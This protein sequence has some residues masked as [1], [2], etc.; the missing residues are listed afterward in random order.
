MPYFRP[1]KRDKVISIGECGAEFVGV[2]YADE[3]GVDILLEC[4]P[5][6]ADK[7]IELWNGTEP[8]DWK[9]NDE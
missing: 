9:G 4:D 8:Y 3:D 6:I 1:I 5:D 2:Y 7:I